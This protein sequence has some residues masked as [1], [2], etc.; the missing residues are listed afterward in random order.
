MH[1][2]YISQYRNRPWLKNVEARKVRRSDS[3][4]HL[5]VFAGLFLLNILIV[6]VGFPVLIYQKLKGR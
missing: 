5:L 4:R 3:L 2:E 1:C 6:M